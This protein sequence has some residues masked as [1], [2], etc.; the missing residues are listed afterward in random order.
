MTPMVSRTFLADML[1]ET[2]YENDHPLPDQWR[3]SSPGSAPAVMVPLHLID[4][5][6]LD[7][8]LPGLNG[9]GKGCSELK[10]TE[11]FQDV[12]VIII[13]GLR[14][15]NTWSRPLPQAPSIT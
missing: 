12:P 7:I 9:I 8:N 4:L 14:S 10:R 15:R 13:S 6:L 5:V 3:R 1:H 2:G 11:Q